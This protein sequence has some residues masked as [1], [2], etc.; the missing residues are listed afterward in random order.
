LRFAAR[1]CP[2]LASVNQGS[3]EM[4]FGMAS[5]LID[6]IEGRLSGPGELIL[7]PTEYKPRESVGPAPRPLV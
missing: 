2:R 7:T 3:Y 5:R 1:T 6:R 4:G